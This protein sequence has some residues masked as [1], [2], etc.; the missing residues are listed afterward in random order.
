VPRGLRRLDPL[1]VVI[2]DEVRIS[3]RVAL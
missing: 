2:G 1:F 3:I